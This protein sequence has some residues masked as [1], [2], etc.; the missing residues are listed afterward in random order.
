MEEG[1]QVNYNV[2]HLN[3]GNDANGN[4]RRLYVLLKDQH[5]HKVWDEGYS[6]YNGVSPEWREDAKF[7]PSFVTTPKE[8]KRLRKIGA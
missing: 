1:R 8:Y 6:G 7:A 3:A 4:P 2:I 5:I